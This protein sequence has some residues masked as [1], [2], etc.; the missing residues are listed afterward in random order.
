MPKKKIKN[1]QKNCKKE[2]KKMK[3][4]PKNKIQKNNETL[5]FH[6]IWMVTPDIPPMHTKL[7]TTIAKIYKIFNSTM[8]K[9]Y[10]LCVIVLYSLCHKKAVS[11]VSKHKST[12]KQKQNSDKK[13]SN[14]NLCYL[15]RKS[16]VSK[17]LV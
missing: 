13:T 6:K 15:E 3:C 10:L 1:K 4:T 8:F 2:N 16:K 5:V 14:E 11:L 7:P 9:F 17:L 12:H